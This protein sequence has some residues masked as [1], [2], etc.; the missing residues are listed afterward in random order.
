MRDGNTW[1]YNVGGQYVP[2]LL[3]FSQPLQVDRIE[4]REREGLSYLREG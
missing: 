2:T 3:P 1:V 4:H